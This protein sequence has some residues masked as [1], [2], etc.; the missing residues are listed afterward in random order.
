MQCPD[1]ARGPRNA[2]L[3]TIRPDGTGLRVLRL[4]MLA[5]SGAWAP[6]GDAITFRCQPQ[7]GPPRPGV[8]ALHVAARRQ[9]PEGVSD[10]AAELGS[11]RLGNAAMRIGG[12]STIRDH[13]S[14]EPALMRIVRGLGV[15]LLVASPVL[16][17]GCG[18]RSG[19]DKAG[20]EAGRLRSS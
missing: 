7:A 16:A 11:P 1:G 5:D 13:G 2:R 14:H 15:C 9:R 10:R 18:G 4:G 3:A 20:P 6:D 17:T 19:L 12:H 8:P